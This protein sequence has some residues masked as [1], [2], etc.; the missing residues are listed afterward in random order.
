[1]LHL[2]RIRILIFIALIFVVA[3]LTWQATMAQAT[4]ARYFPETGHWVTDEFLIKYLDSPN[5][6]T[7]Y[8]NPITEAFVDSFGIQVQYFEKV[9][10][11]LDSSLPQGL[12]VKLSPLGEYLYQEGQVLSTPTNFPACRYFPESDHS[13][14]YSFLDFFEGHGGISQFGY[15]ISGFEIHEDWIVQYFQNARFEWHPENLYGEYVVVSDLGYRYFNDRGEDPRR[16][17]PI[18]EEDNLIVPVL[19]LRP[20]AFVSSAVLP[21]G[22]TQTLYVIV[23]DQNLQPVPDAQVEFMIEF[24][25]G[26][27]QEFRISDTNESGVSTFNFKVSTNAKGIAQIFVVVTYDNS[28][29]GQTRTSFQIW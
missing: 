27:I 11:E 1:M 9:R 23:Q 2:K 22:E 6:R 17:N 12:Q 4:N 15:P 8:G 14:C 18:I 25:D 19:R 10:F 7:L 29:T 24:S 3:G 20:K 28:L 21:L 13:V 5:P 26:S 16:L